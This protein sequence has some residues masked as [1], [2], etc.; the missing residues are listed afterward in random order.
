MVEQ[1]LVVAVVAL[2]IV[3]ALQ[4]WLVARLLSRVRVLEARV[5]AIEE[6]VPRP[7]E[8]EEGA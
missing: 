4:T 8:H 7:W 3:S 1:A 2:V 5:I 6:V